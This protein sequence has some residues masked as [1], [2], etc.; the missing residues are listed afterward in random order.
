MQNNVATRSTEA[1]LFL[2]PPMRPIAKH[3]ASTC[4]KGLWRP[5]W[6]RRG[7]RTSATSFGLRVNATYA[8]TTYTLV[9]HE[10]LGS[11]VGLLEYELAQAAQEQQ[12]FFASLVPI[13]LSVPSAFWKFSVL[14]KKCMAAM[15]NESS[16]DEH[17]GT[18]A[19][20]MT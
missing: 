9:N 1:R 11:R 17:D 20:N 10:Y 5:R 19:E 18:P 3:I 16:S 12:A 4:T 8:N 2:H 14:S 6:T 15:T 13:S 7:F